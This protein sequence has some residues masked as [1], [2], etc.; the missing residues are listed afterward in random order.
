[1]AMDFVHETAAFLAEQ[2][3]ARER[4]TPNA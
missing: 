2:R 4:S 1:V 3:R